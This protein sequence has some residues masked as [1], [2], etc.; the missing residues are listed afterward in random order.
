L[1]YISLYGGRPLILYIGKYVGL[2]E[3]HLTRTEK[4]FDTRGEW[5]VFFG[6]FIPG[7]RS[8]MSIPA[9][10]SKMNIMKFSIFT[11][12]GSLIWSTSLEAGGYVLGKSWNSIIPTVTEIGVALLAAFSIGL[13]AYISYR[14]YLRK[15]REAGQV[16][17]EHSQEVKGT[18]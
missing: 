9:G 2:K 10:V 18:R 8:Y 1:Y 16:S 5:T 7:F 15:K 11:F 17:S 14:I 12:S 4:W 6:R 3:E 13:V